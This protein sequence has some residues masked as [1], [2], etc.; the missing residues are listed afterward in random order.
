MVSKVTDVFDSLRGATSM[1]C[2]IETSSRSIGAAVLVT[3]RSDLPTMGCP[4]AST[5]RHVICI[6]PRL[7]VVSSSPGEH[8]L[9]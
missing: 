6:M 4:L 8:A 5:R 1:R 7:M 9:S 2:P 3:S